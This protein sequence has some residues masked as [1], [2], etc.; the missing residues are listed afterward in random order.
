MT[1]AFITAQSRVA[2]ALPAGLVR[3]IAAR[4]AAAIGVVFA[5]SVVVFLFVH[6][7]PGGP[8]YAIA[9]PMA[10]PDQLAAIRVKHDLDAPLTQQ[11]ADYL[12]ALLHGDLGDSFMRKTSVTTALR[13]AAGITVPLMLA[14]WVLSL[15]F[16]VAL[17]IV[18]ASRPGGWLDRL[19]VSLTTVGASAPAFAVGTLLAWLF[20]I[21]LGWLPVLGSGNG[22]NTLAHLILPAV[23]AS[24]ML[25]A[26]TTKFTRVRVGQILGE[27]QMTFARSRG[28]SRRWVLRNV[29]LRNAGVQ[30]VT[31]SGS[32]LVSLIAGLI[33]VEQVFNLPGLGTLMVES[34]RD[35]DIAVVQG[36]ALVAAML[37]VGVNLVADLVCFA[38]DPRLRASLTRGR[39]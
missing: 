2:A 17:G 11:Y 9:G 5:V 37:V 36:V 28:L 26:A 13:G 34:I 4:L 35:R 15:V 20:G 16:G 7:A 14:T 25:L 10:T 3:Y 6:A 19:V 33:I 39:R 12:G 1:A 27:D 31:L 38:V 8:E 29:V 30:L 32:M 22:A 21:K 23:T 24:V 18:T